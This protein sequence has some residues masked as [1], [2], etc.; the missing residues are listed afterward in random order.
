MFGVHPSPLF[1]LG[2]MKGTRMQHL[3]WML[4]KIC[5]TNRARG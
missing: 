2:A 1:M 5:K 4:E 3:T